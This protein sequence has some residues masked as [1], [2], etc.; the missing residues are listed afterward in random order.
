MLGGAEVIQTLLALLIG[1]AVADYPLQGDYLARSKNR[2]DA[3]GAHGIWMHSLAAHALIH[4]GA[5]WLITGSLALGAA[6]ACAH[7]AIDFAKCDGRLTY[8]ADQA[9]HVACKVLW[10]WLLWRHLV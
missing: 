5:V 1:H 7:A 3:L 6:E 8:H 2:H 9:L 10:A 4:G